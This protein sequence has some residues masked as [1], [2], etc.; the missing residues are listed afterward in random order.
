[1]KKIVVFIGV[2]VFLSVSLF[3]SVI[4]ARDGGHGGFHNGGHFYHGGGPRVFIGGYFGFP[5]YYPYRH[6]YPLYPYP[7]PYAD[8]Q[9]QV[10]SEP[11]E[12]YYWYYCSDSQTY[13]PYV[14]SCASAWVK[15]VPTPPQS[16]KN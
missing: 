6:Y 1:M 7:R 5:Y 15:V 10:Y 4:Y 11:Q 12:Q 9:P 13:Y 8:T 2:C 16:G 3:S 14:T